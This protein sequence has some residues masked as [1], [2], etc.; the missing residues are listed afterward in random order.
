VGLDVVKRIMEIILFLLTPSLVLI[1][2]YGFITPDNS[3]TAGSGA[4][5]G[6]LLLRSL[7]LFAHGFYCIA[8]R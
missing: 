7:V 2:S 5:P 4:D 3:D 1:M 8:G 6:C